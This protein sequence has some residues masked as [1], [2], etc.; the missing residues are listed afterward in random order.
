[1]NPVVAVVMADGESTVRAEIS[2]ESFTS[3]EVHHGARVSAARRFQKHSSDNANSTM[4]NGD[5][6]RDD[7][8]GGCDYGYPRH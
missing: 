8:C 1:M 3:E 4:L 7:T 5:L 2:K 6:L